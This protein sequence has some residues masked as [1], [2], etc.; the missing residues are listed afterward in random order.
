MKN[1]L[2]ASFVIGLALVALIAAVNVQAQSVQINGIGSS[3]LFFDLGLA[4]STLNG[5]AGGMCVWS[6]TGITSGAIANAIDTSMITPL[7]DSGPA[8]VTWTPSFGQSANAQT[9][10]GPNVTSTT[11]VWAY[12]Q[13]D[14]VVGNRC[15]FHA[16]TTFGSQC[17]VFYPTNDPLPE[18]FVLTSP[19]AEFPL[20]PQIANAL[21]NTLVNMAGTDIRPE[22]A[23]FATARAL[24]PC[25]TSVT[26]GS[27][28]LGLGYNN[29]DNI[30]SFFN[31]FGAHL[32]NFTLPVSYFVTPIG[33]TPIVVVVNGDSTGFN[34]PSSLVTNL[35]SATLAMF[36]DGI[37]SFTGQAL[38]TPTAS[39]APVTVVI[40]EPL[41]GTSNTMEF[42]VPNTTANQTSQDVGLNQ[43]MGQRDCNPVG[44]GLNPM[45]LMTASGGHRRR[46]IGTEQELSEVVDTA[47]NGNNSLSY[48][49]WSVAN[50]RFFSNA[51]AANARYLTID[52]IDPLI[53]RSAAYTGV[54]PTTG[55]A[56][57]ANVSLNS[58]ANGTYPIWSIL[59]LV[60]VDSTSTVA[61]A[62]L[63]NATKALVSFGTTTARPDFVVAENMQVVRS[64]FIP[65]AGVGLPA[66]AADGHVGL[67]TS[68]CTSP[69]AGG[70]VGGQ[71]LTLRADAAF[72]LVTGVTTGQTG[73]RR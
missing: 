53:T 35:S 24:T 2:K 59:R 40:P 72:C 42:N 21:N 33:A 55:S 31:N 3:A 57:L 6:S 63:A 4:A 5:I 56:T 12:L 65:P 15:L 17:T 8:W 27:Q 38:A 68:P 50:F 52:G 64:H 43:P 32:L 18:N 22:D 13:T 49:F 54:I 1:L 51:L 41:S 67:P 60:T 71:V 45:N 44:P 9:C 11:K 20:P 58:V 61:A 62:T 23:V 29:G 26:T 7:S 36:L 14:S 16:H 10:N 66:S 46:A 48:G 39:G 37:F 34:N 19:G 73:R 69:E 30:L 28:Y 25:A 70:D 47:N